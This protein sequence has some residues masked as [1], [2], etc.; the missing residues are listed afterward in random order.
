MAKPNPIVP[1]PRIS[2]EEFIRR[3]K[4]LMNK[5]KKI[6]EYID[7]EMKMEEVLVAQFLSKS[8]VMKGPEIGLFSS[9]AYLMLYVLCM[10]GNS[11][12]VS[13][14]FSHLCSFTKKIA[15]KCRIPSEVSECH[16]AGA[17]PSG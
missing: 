10:S 14:S 1:E 9:L 13:Q 12:S 17:D 7:H 8:D 15:I 11:K 4:A 6:K 3:M 2:D 5:P 16:H